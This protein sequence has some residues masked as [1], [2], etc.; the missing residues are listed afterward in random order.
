MNLLS[1]LYQERDVFLKGDFK[2]PYSAG[3][4]ISGHLKFGGEYRKNVHT[5][6][7]STPYF[8]PFGSIDPN[9]N[10]AQNTVR[11]I[12]NALQQ[13]FGLTLAGN[14]QYRGSWFTS[15]DS[16][17][18][19]S[20]LGNNFG[21]FYYAIDGSLLNT[22]IDF[23]RSDTSFNA[24]KSSPSAP[25]GWTD[26]Y[27]AEL[28]NDYDYTENYGAGYLMTQ[29]NVG[30]VLTIIGGA[31]YEEITSRFHAYNLV[32]RRNAQVQD[33]KEVVSTPSNHFLLP[34]IQAKYNL[35]DWSDI[36]YSY[37]QTLARPDYSQLSPHYTISQYSKQIWAG[38]PNLRPM[39]STN[40]DLMLTFHSNELGLFSVGAFYKE[41][42]D[43]SYSTSYKLRDHPIG[44]GQDSLGSFSDQ[45][46]LAGGDFTLYTYVNNPSLSYIRG[47]EFDLQT[48]FWYLPF[49]FDG[50]LLGLNYTHITSETTY[51]YRDEYTTGKPPHQTT[52][53]VDSTRAGRMLNQPNDIA[54]IFVGY[55]YKGFS[56]K[57]TL[58]YQGNS[59]SYIGA[60]P[61]YDGF[62]ADY[63]R[64][65]LSIRQTLPWS[66][67]QIFLD[68]TNLNNRQNISRQVSIDGFTNQKNYGLQANLGV[69]YIYA[70]D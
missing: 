55:D 51:P 53:I 28:A 16:K 9:V 12:T 15:H 2:I 25:G 42:K 22:M 3:N 45:V 64:V 41:I 5:N 62:T 29:L 48:R 44:A 32:D 34:M 65:D 35:F 8:R 11:R 6:D 27:Y 39:Q 50:L 40:H 24:Y 23:I 10:P 67:L 31:R 4:N 56:A 14:G 36:R 13:Q 46:N 18:Y 38:N 66:G 58:A 21:Q 68:I 54:N 57:V 47:V 30:S 33:Y 26:D 70:F 19:D 52:V 43:F 49:P 37:S 7:Q 69:R 17:M 60:F 1:S 20:F 61:E 63:F 59:V